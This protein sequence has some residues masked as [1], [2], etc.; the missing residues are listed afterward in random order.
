M[1]TRTDAE[2]PTPKKIVVV[3]ASGRM[4]ALF[5]EW[6]QEVGL[7]MVALNRPYKNVE[8]TVSD[9]DLVIVSVPAKVFEDVLSVLIPH[10]PPKAIL[11]DVVSVKETPLR[12][13]ER[14]WGGDIV[15]T[16][17]LFGPKNEPGDDLPVAI[18]PGKNCSSKAIAIVESFY[19][20][21]GCRVFRTTA[22]KHDEAVAR[23]QNLNFVT[24][25][26]YFAALAENRDLLP[27]LT[28]SFERRKKS[29]A[30]MLTE[31]A[32]M[33]AG[34]FDANPHSHEA[35]RQYRKMLN[36]AASG[37]IDLLC[38]RARWWWSPES[39]QDK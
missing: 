3:G 9:A 16:H 32:E 20:R 28:P 11:T 18:V 2:S 15:G 5:M 35:A 14:L 27:F 4:G 38:K 6:G 30:K 7:N 8:E 25:L 26:A 34:L 17:P 12:Q 19:R 24:N 33:F 13:M 39:D 37:D 1:T 21:L 23:I 10:L 29:A 22:K 36:I 31:D